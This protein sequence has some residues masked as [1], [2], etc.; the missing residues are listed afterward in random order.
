MDDKFILMGL[1]DENSKKVAE[2]LQNK[3][4]RKILDYLG[5]VREA[6]EKD[7]STGLGVALNTV[8]YNL[9][10]LIEVG[11]V[12][13]TKNFFWSVKGKKI[14][15]YKLA[16]KHII[17][18]PNKKPSLD[19]LKALLPVVLIALVAIAIVAVVQTGKMNENFQ[20]SLDSTSL[21]AF[22]SYDEI[23]AFL[24]QSSDTDVSSYSFATGGARE[25]TI[26]GGAQNAAPNVAKAES[27][28]AGA[29]LGSVGTRSSTGGTDDYS[30]TNIQVEGVDEAD[31]VKNDGQYIYVV[32]G[33]KVVIVDAYPAE[34]MEKVS[35][36]EFDDPVRNIFLDG[37]RLV[38]MV[39][40]YE[41]IDSGMPC[42]DFYAFGVRC[43]GYSREEARVFVY[44]ITDRADPEE[45]H[46]YSVSGN[47][48]DARLIDGTLYM[49]ST[50]YLYGGSVDIPYYV[51]DGV[52][53]KIAAGDIYYPGV[54][55]S[56]YV[57]NTVS[58]LDVASGEVEAQT[59]LLGSSQ[60][61]YV[62]EENIYLTYQKE[63]PQEEV[64][65]GY[66]DEVLLPLLPSDV[67]GEISDVWGSDESYGSK[68]RDISSILEDFMM[69]LSVEERYEFQLELEDEAF[70]YFEK[71]SEEQEK[72][73]VH[74]LAIDGLDISHEATGEVPGRVLNQFSMDEFDGNFRIATTTGGWNRDKNENHLYVLDSDLE[75]IG[76]VEGLA[77][78]E[79]IYSA[80][81]MGERA[82]MV[83]F[84]QTDPLFAIDLSDPK[85]PTVMGELKV[86][87]YSGY[88][89]PYDENHLLGIGMEA[90]ESGRTTG[91]K[92]SL[93]DVSDMS[94]PR[95]IGK[96][97]VTEGKWSS[98]EA[99]YDHKAVLFDREKNLLV[100]P[101]SYNKEV[102][103]EGQT[104]PRYESWQG[105]YVFD[106]SL[107]GIDLRG[108][109]IHE[110]NESD[111]YWYGSGAYV[112]RSLY[113]DDVLYTI[114]DKKV[115]A[116]ALA[117]L[118]DI[119]M[120]DLPVE[121]YYPG[122]LYYA[123]GDVAVASVGAAEPAPP[124]VK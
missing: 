105:A 64:L 9:K 49:I 122:P 52:E 62:S 23:E 55:S 96:Y 10:K 19:A 117:D 103:V 115:K 82:Y 73:I 37:D 107:E 100:I 61:M 78:G 13:K 92:V 120:V 111:E 8:E 106:V 11:L 108:T 81:F 16:K 2:V 69:D 83:T 57:F 3:T 34:S 76:S 39:D 79:Q 60:T 86:T 33:K 12:E 15:M 123:E 30:G 47:Y 110:T 112:R 74:R 58:A 38:V 41:Y 121:S 24:K 26:M 28:D 20:G 42:G 113:M 25:A 6:S 80:R 50:K 99:V 77:E 54:R 31:I 29:P 7:I 68:Q 35:E 109:V 65:D 59:Y 21:N 51:S 36:I 116:N 32:S 1:G 27:A 18:S 67:A 17:I 14:P 114:S 84:R 66:L 118:D 53:T 91:V 93:F 43:G 102:V 124:M 63:I 88:L 71:V 75:T 101:V 104:W 89:H 94:N 85:N 48:F 44:D 87:G 46:D 70:A 98:S 90:T 72:T 97:E 56:S 119:S 45:E 95:E 5:D 22:N 4:A 40:H